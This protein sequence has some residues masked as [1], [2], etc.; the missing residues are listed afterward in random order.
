MSVRLHVSYYEIAGFS[1]AIFQ[2]SVIL[3]FELVSLSLFLSPIS[4]LKRS[5]TISVTIFVFL[6]FP[7]T[8]LQK[9]RGDNISEK[10]TTL[11]TPKISFF[12]FFSNF[13]FRRVGETLISIEI[14]I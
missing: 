4:Y 14:K 1:T 2:Q 5:R 3:R 9:Q 7:C 6:R 8:I 10:F 12:N 11:E 13:E